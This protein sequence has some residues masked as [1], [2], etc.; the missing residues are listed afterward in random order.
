MFPK[1]KKQAGNLYI[2]AIFVIVVMGFLAA[3]LT[4]IEWSNQDALSRDVLG[5][6]AWFAAHS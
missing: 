6:Q 2:V 1:I 3:A 4:R 5:T